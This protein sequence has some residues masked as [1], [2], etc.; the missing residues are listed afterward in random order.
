M[1]IDLDGKDGISSSIHAFGPNGGFVV[2]LGQQTATGGIDTPVT[3]K[4]FT[5]KYKTSERGMIYFDP[6]G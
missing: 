2:D 3:F 6:S 4:L 1:Q 5:G